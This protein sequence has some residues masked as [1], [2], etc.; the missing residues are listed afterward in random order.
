MPGP[1]EAPTQERQSLVVRSRA[2]PSRQ[3]SLIR[4]VAVSCSV[5]CRTDP[6]SAPGTEGRQFRSLAFYRANENPTNAAVFSH[7]MRSFPPESVMSTNEI[8][9]SSTECSAFDMVIEA[10]TTSNV[11]S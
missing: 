8:V 1:R 2:K 4:S 5:L 10:R 9:N 3:A 11:G 7:S 6:E